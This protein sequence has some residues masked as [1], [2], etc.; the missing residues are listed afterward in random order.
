MR[1]T[2]ED[3]RRNQIPDLDLSKYTFRSGDF[4]SGLA[5]K[6]LREVAES[7]QI[8]P[9]KAIDADIVHCL[10]AFIDE[11][12]QQETREEISSGEHSSTSPALVS[13][14]G[15]FLDLVVQHGYEEARRIAPEYF[16]DLSALHSRLHGQMLVTHSSL[17]SF[18]NASTNLL[19]A[20]GAPLKNFENPQT[21][22]TFFAVLGEHLVG[23]A[24][25]LAEVAD[26]I[27]VAVQGTSRVLAEDAKHSG[28][29]HLK[30]GFLS[31]HGFSAANARVLHDA[32]QLRWYSDLE[33]AL[34]ELD[35]FFTQR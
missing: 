21:T 22:Q 10:R 30:A 2:A 19:R 28:S 23:D 27:E 32:A 14:A 20:L 6:D 13:A 12:R 29:A 4:R 31:A 25:S 1:V 11:A 5:Q 17:A 3:I 7:A 34:S 16:N 35:R 24:K 8:L 15:K 26:G 18:Q 33:K 9:R